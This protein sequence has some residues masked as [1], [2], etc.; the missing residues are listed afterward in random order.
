MDHLAKLRCRKVLSLLTLL[1]VCAGCAPPPPRDTHSADVRTIT[2]GEMLWVRPWTIRDAERIVARYAEDATVMAPNMAPA[3]GR[4][5][6]LEMVK[7]LVRDGNF[8]LTFEV[9]RVEVARSGD[10][11]YVEGSYTLVATAAATRKPFTDRGTYL[12]V[13]RKQLDGA[14]KVL[15]DMRASSLAAASPLVEQ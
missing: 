3:I 10:L 6:I 8:A 5:A 9:G 15:L 11:G 2:E 1:A 14:W 13:Y 4:E 7:E 12:R